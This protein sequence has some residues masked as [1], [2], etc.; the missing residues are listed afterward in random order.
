MSEFGN[1]TIVPTSLRDQLMNIPQTRIEEVVSELLGTEEQDLELA[2]VVVESIKE[3]LGSQS[4]VFVDADTEF[5]A[6]KK[7][8][9]A[10]IPTSQVVIDG[11]EI[12]TPDFSSNTLDG[13]DSKESVREIHHS[14]LG[15][16][17]NDQLAATTLRE[18]YFNNAEHHLLQEVLFV[19]DYSELSID[20]REMLHWLIKKGIKVIVAKKRGEEIPGDYGMIL[21]KDF[22]RSPYL[23]SI[24]KK[25]DEEQS[26]EAKSANLRLS[27]RKKVA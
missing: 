23:R 26:D 4:A 27:D 14:I 3:V 24:E 22:V 17:D 21:S 5:E 13:S 25:P 2:E 18:A 19:K 6:I 11:S 8:I 9:E 1:E 16:E 15:K 20:L 10:E 7:I 12:T